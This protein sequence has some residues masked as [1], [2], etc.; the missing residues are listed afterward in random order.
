MPSTSDTATTTGPLRR[1]METIKSL[2]A[3]L[4]AARGARR[5]AV[6]G[7]GL[8][9]PGGIDD[10]ET[11]WRA[12]AEGRDLTGELPARRRGV[13]GADWDGLLSRG[14]YLDDVFGFDA[15]FFG[16]SPREAR[17]LDPQ[18]RLLLQ[19]VWEAFED[20]AIPPAS[21]AG[22][23]G[24]F[25]GITGQDYRQWAEPDPNAS[26]LIGNGHCFAA[27]RIAYTLGL[28]GPTMAIDTA[29]SSSL[30]AVHTACRALTAGDCDVAVAGGVSLVLAPRST[31][32]IQRTDALSP[33]GR[34][35]PFDARANGFVR[36]EGCGA[37]VL[38]RLG[39]AERD[40]D[41]VLAVIEGTGVNQDGPSAGFTAPNG[42]AQTRLIESV[43]ASTGLT[44]DDIGYLEAHG[45]GTPLGDPIELEAAAT[46]LSG[47]GRTWYVGSV[48]ANVGHTESAAGVLG[49]LKALLCL[50][51][52]Q[53]PRQARFERLNPRIDLG[54]SGMTV[55]T[56]TVP[57]DTTSSGR[58]AA[59]S[60]F[61]M[62]GTNA[63]AVLSPGPGTPPHGG[64]P[65]APGG[66]LVS[67]HT[68]PALRALALRYAAALAEPIAETDFAAFAYTATHGRTR[69]RRAAWIGADSAAQAREALIALGNG[70]DDPRLRTL[71]GTEAV[72]ADAT[73]R[74]VRSLPFY[75]WEQVT[76]SIR[77][78]GDD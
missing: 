31:A 35:R 70:I 13:F 34:C 41:R 29:C 60:S 55:P 18:H 11:Y 58:C 9:A 59:V 40:G 28:G 46:A 66:L 24:V 17:S 14:G 53:I 72:P 2:R 48:K 44:A 5:I 49:L 73:A 39:D 57:W 77:A 3:E 25:V 71:A 76:H 30:T 63:H 38:K 45:T 10:R 7:T 54:D 42:P 32:E 33:D 1:A 62:S 21:V 12:L 27:G 56:R 52:R 37:V 68:E 75:P 67:A 20:A 6:V 65:S 15:K 4:D 16:I 78:L 19:V 64:A 50:E 23:T 51:K 74:L 36:G 26:W 43:L 61:G 69:L 47:G 8:R 22:S